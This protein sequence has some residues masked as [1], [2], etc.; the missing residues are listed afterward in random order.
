ME[1][2]EQYVDRLII[3]KKFD[4]KDPDVVAQ[5]KADLMDRVEDRINAM[6]VRELKEEELGAFE[7]L[8]DGSPI[9]DI[10]AFVKQH[11]SNLDEKI[12]QELVEFRATYLS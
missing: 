5:I 8:L 11:I 12:A 10:N 7:K 3:E 9:E 4:E 6:I 1:Q 2:L